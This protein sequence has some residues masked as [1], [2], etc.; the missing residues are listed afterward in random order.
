MHEIAKSLTK[1]KLAVLG[2]TAS[3]AD[4]NKASDT[5]VDQAKDQAYDQARK[6][7]YRQRHDD[8][9]EVR[10]AREEAHATGA[11]FG[12]SQNEIGMHIENRTFD[13]WRAWAEGQ[14]V[15][16]E[17]A[18]S[19]A[20]SGGAAGGAQGSTTKDDGVESLEGEQGNA[21]V[22]ELQRSIPGSKSGQ[23]A[24]GGAATR[25]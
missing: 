13:Q 2:P 16:M 18:K 22:E 10:V 8:E 1:E 25:P 14:V 17:Q 23:R 11:Y 9:V 15:L 7:F 3:Q 21:V 12:L 5:A 20:Y 24:L 4:K 6:E 19:A